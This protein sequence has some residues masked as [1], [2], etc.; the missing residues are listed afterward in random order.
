MPRAAVNKTKRRRP[1]KVKESAVISLEQQDN[2]I[3]EERMAP[4][5]ATNVIPPLASVAEALSATNPD[6]PWLA[7]FAKR[8]EEVGIGLGVELVDIVRPG[9]HAI[10]VMDDERV[11]GPYEKAGYEIAMKDCPWLTRETAFKVNKAGEL[12]YGDCIIMAITLEEFNRIMAIPAKRK[13]EEMEAMKQRGEL[14]MSRGAPPPPDPDE[15]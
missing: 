15:E 3:D 11:R 8:A 6:R 2:P 9:V 7:A 10:F 4:A 13:Q 14:K 12:T 1:A 5:T